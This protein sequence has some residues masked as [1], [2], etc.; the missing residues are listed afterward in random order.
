MFMNE[1]SIEQNEEYAIFVP[2]AESFKSQIFLK[3]IDFWTLHVERKRGSD[4]FSFRGERYI[5]KDE[6][7]PKFDLCKY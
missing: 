1:K 3:Q 6:Y 5:F 2:Q 7:R 4:D